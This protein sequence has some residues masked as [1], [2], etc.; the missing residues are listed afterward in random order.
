MM[1]SVRIF[2]IIIP[3]F[4]IYF[5]GFPQDSGRLRR[6]SIPPYFRLESDRIKIHEFLDLCKDERY[7]PFFE[8]LMKM[9]DV[10]ALD[11]WFYYKVINHYMSEIYAQSESDFTR[12]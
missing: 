10:Y 4:L 7:D 3:C 11:D 8:G 6:D 2:S 9:K 5:N 12:L 1:K